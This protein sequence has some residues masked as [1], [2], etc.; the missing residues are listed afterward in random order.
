MSCPD[1]RFWPIGTARKT[2]E[3]IKRTDVRNE[4]MM[5]DA[6]NGRESPLR[7]SHVGPDGQRFFSMFA[8]LRV[9]Q[10]EETTCTK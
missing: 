4:F 5:G 10:V 1:T 7:I 8:V 9:M 2:R 6:P 3:A